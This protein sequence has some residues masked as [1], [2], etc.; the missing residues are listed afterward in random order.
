M[1][2][3]SGLQTQVLALYRSFLRVSKS[4]DPSPDSE[5]TSF[6]RREFRKYAKI[7]RF[8]SANIEYRIRLGERQLE[9]LRNGSI[10]GFSVVHKDHGHEQ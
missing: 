8:D 7:H 3:R 10:A 5:L 9:R 1:N 2:R 6:I 4:K